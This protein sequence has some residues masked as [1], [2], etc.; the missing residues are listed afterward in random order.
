LAAR[1]AEQARESNQPAE[2]TVIN[3]QPIE[4]EPITFD[5]PEFE[6]DDEVTQLLTDLRT[7][8]TELRAEE[9]PPLDANRLLDFGISTQYLREV[10]GLTDNIRKLESNLAAAR[11]QMKVEEEAIG[12]LK[13]EFKTERAEPEP[14]RAKP[15]HLEEEIKQREKCLLCKPKTL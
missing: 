7:I 4:H 2:P 13:E 12:K 3:R 6:D 5:N 15:K 9:E 1:E 8:N 10:G 11:I 14:D